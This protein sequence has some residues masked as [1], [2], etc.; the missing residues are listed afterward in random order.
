VGE[1]KKKK[2]VALQGAQSDGPEATKETER[3][4]KGNTG[5]KGGNF[6][7]FR[8]KRPVQLNGRKLLSKK[9]KEKVGGNKG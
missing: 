7:V 9:K 5:G 8:G 3:K 4:L 1:R 6:W 2:D